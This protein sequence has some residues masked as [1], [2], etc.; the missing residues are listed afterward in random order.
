MQRVVGGG[1]FGVEVQLDVGR[2][3][4][5]GA[6]QEGLLRGPLGVELLA[7]RDGLVRGNAGGGNAAATL[8][9]RSQN[10]AAP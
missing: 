6:R 10:V 5:G 8:D 9:S 3:R 1:A 7:G 4:G 2:G